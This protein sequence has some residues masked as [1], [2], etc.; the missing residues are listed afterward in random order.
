MLQAVPEFEAPVPGSLGYKLRQGMQKLGIT[1]DD[2]YGN[3][4]DDG[5]DCH[6]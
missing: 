5:T 2:L 1:Y 3:N 4:R 6:R